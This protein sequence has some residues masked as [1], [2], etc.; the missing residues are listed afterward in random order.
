M[1][2]GDDEYS[3]VGLTTRGEMLKGKW[4]LI[5]GASR[6]VGWT[7]AEKFASEQANLIL[8]AR[9]KDDLEKVPPLAAGCSVS[10]DVHL[11]KGTLR[12]VASVAVQARTYG[13]DC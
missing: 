4:A 7:I 9:S 6:G 5:T 3:K 1:Q 2:G 11:D 12:A 13:N 8:V 10:Q